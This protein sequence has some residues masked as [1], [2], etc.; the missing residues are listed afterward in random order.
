MDDDRTIRRIDDENEIET[1]IERTFNSWNV[2][3]SMELSIWY[4]PCEWFIHVQQ[5]YGIWNEF[6]MSKNV[7]KMFK[8]SMCFHLWYY[9]KNRNR[10]HGIEIR[11]PKLLVPTSCF[12][13]Q[14]ISIFVCSKSTSPT[15][16]TRVLFREKKKFAWTNEAVTCKH[17]SVEHFKWFAGAFLKKVYESRQKNLNISRVS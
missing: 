3:N 15:S 16:E 8:S 7:Q 17:F 14:W 4:V 9:V 5:I 6:Q 11:S 12:I 10:S 2:Q 1:E 13:V